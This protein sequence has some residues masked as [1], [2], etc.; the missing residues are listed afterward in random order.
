MFLLNQYLYVY[1]NYYLQ[2]IKEEYS[3]MKHIGVIY[4]DLNNLKEINDTYGHDVGDIIIIKLAKSISYLL[5]E[6]IRAYR[7]GGDEFIVIIEDGIS[8]VA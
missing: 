1:K 3:S 4:F 5:D 8:Y 2:A 7:I 6:G